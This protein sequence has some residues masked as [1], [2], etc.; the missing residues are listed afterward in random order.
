M[1]IQTT[2]ESEMTDQQFETIMTKLDEIYHGYNP[3]DQHRN[4]K[5]TRRQKVLT[6]IFL[7]VLFMATFAFHRWA[8]AGDDRSDCKGC[9]TTNAGPSNYVGPGHGAGSDPNFVYGIHQGMCC[10]PN[11]LTQQAIN[12]HSGLPFSTEVAYAFARDMYDRWAGNQ[13]NGGGWGYSNSGW[14]Q[15]DRGAYDYGSYSGGA[16]MRGY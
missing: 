10:G 16:G 5:M 2:G 1:I 4:K 8:Y 12:N 11:R 3:N 6:T 13:Y 14:H 7:L 9:R 15:D